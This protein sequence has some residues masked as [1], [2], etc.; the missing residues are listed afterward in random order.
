MPRG[1]LTSSQGG[2]DAIRKAMLDDDLIECII[3]LPGQLFFNV[4]IPSCLW[5]F[6]KDKSKWKNNRKK[7]VLFIDARK[8]GTP[9]SRTQIEFSDEEIAKI[10]DTFKAWAYGKYEDVDGFCASVAR[11]EIAN[12]GDA[13]S[14]GRYIGTEENESESDGEFTERIT[15]LVERLSE[16][17]EKS[18]QLE[19]SIS[20]NLKAFGYGL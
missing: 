8:L 18:N 16:Q 10:A 6:N 12:N 4:Q 17:I 7:Q 3:D 19:S 9:I 14:P 15:S 11:E 2:D 13:L 1:T 5:F 20:D